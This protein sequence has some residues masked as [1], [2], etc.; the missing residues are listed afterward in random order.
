MTPPQID[1]WM[2]PFNQ[3]P[4][5]E[6]TIPTFGVIGI[7]GFDDRD[8]ELL[9]VFNTAS[10]GVPTGL[11][12][13]RYTVGSVR[14]SVTVAN[15]NVWLYEPSVRANNDPDPKRPVELFGAGFRGPWNVFNFQNTTTFF[16]ASCNPQPAQ[17][18]RSVFPAVFDSAGAAIDV[19]NQLKNN[20]SVQPFATGIAAE[21]N[22]GDP[23]PEGT[24]LTFDLNLCDPTVR[25]YVQRGLRDGRLFLL[26]STV[27]PTS[28]GPGGGDGPYPR[29]Y[30][31]D[32][33][34][35]TAPALD[36]DVR[37]GAPGDVD[38]SGF[39]DSDDFVAFIQ[40]FT[41][42]CTGNGQSI[43]GADSACEFSADFDGSCFIDSDDFSAFVAAFQLG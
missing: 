26:L 3:N 27:I 28:G 30:T 5:V 20:L 38:G 43:F 29:F 13:D 12:L 21:L 19:S 31:Q 7:P 33:P 36:L 24:T 32:N 14:L 16:G 11:A 4:G 8:S 15:N 17:N 35:G 1:R 42:G 37:F 6:T 22:A 40:A 23:V 25:A 18:C 2:Y 34:L 10:A 9:V 39:V 41:R